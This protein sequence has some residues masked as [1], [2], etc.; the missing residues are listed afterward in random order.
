MSM[1]DYLTTDPRSPWNED[2]FD[3][4]PEEKQNKRMT[5]YSMQIF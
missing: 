5:C 4:T 2:T 1:E 3:R